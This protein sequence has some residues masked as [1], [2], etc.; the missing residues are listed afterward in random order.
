M[1]GGIAV[2]IGTPGDRGGPERQ[3]LHGPGFPPLGLI[4]TA[5]GAAGPETE[6]AASRA[7]AFT[8]LFYHCNFTRLFP[9]AFAAGSD[10]IA[11]NTPDERD[12]LYFTLGMLYAANDEDTH[13]RWLKDNRPQII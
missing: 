2:R 1:S 3:R 10:G 12:F 7:A 5:K 8:G 11:D 9:A 13:R 4:L 6:A